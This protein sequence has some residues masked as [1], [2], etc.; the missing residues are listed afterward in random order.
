MDPFRFAASDFPFSGHDDKIITPVPTPP[1]G[2]PRV[3]KDTGGPLGPADQVQA[4]GDHVGRLASAGQAFGQSH[5]V[6]VEGRIQAVL[7]QLQLVTQ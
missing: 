4:G 2:S 3:D 1:S 7:V 6:E 5:L